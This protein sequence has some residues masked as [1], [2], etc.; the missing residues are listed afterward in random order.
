MSAP[1]PWDNY[2]IGNAP[3]NPR[4]GNTRP[5]HACTRKVSSRGKNGYSGGSRNCKRLDEHHGCTQCRRDGLACINEGHIMPPYPE[6]PSARKHPPKCDHCLLL[7][8]PCEKKRPCDA[9]FESGTECTGSTFLCWYR[10][11]PSDS[12]Y[13]YYL[14]HGFGPTGI[15]DPNAIPGWVQPLDYHLQY[16]Q[17]EIDLAN[18]VPQPPQV[19]AHPPMSD[20]A[21]AL[22]LEYR[23]V[24]QLLNTAINNKD[25]D[26]NL[27]AIAA[28]LSVDLINMIPSNQS[29]VARDVMFF[30]Q[31]RTVEFSKS[32]NPFHEAVPINFRGIKGI[33]MNTL[34]LWNPGPQQYNY[35]GPIR[36]VVNTP[37]NGPPSPGPARP[38]FWIPWNIGDNDIPI[39]PNDNQFPPNHPEFI[40][41]EHIRRA[42]FM[43]HPCEDG[44]SELSTIPLMGVTPLLVQPEQCQV[45]NFQGGICGKA[46]QTRCEDRNH[47]GPGMPI[48]AE[49][50]QQSR[51]NF[52]Q[53]LTGIV[54]LLRQYLC[55]ECTSAG[56]PLWN[57]LTNQGWKV[58]YQLPAGTNKPPDLQCTSIITTAMSKKVGGWYQTTYPITGCSCG[59]KLF[60]R[61]ICS[62][63]RLQYLINMQVAATQMREYCKSLYG[64]MVCPLCRARPGIDNYQFQGQAGGEENAIKGYCCLNCHGLVFEGEGGEPVQVV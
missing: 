47:D 45:Q 53:Q 3:V 20:A 6:P 54:P 9:C 32:N 61:V 12:M 5:C 42:P 30:L 8:F 29:Q 1:N 18:G 22:E 44:E 35:L 48:C 41:P 63:H 36:N 59:Y 33:N 60:H 57:N 2:T 51:S 38:T 19:G 55:A 31:Q 58:Y 4:T 26:G 49:H 23:Q 10:G 52:M 16:I 62:P 25:V 56:V 21:R 7:N 46:S 28:Q 39:I 64:R 37:R 15:W 24:L 43:E 14:A 17:R 50:E 34:Q 40:H 13:G 11:V 27:T